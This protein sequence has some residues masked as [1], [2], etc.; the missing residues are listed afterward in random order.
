MTLHVFG[1]TH[2]AFVKIK[3]GGTVVSLNIRFFSV[4]LGLLLR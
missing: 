2:L 1:I 3:I 4:S